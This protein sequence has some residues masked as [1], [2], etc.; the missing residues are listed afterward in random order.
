MGGCGRELDNIFVERFWRSV[1]HEDIY[2]KGNGTPVELKHGLAKYFRFY[3]T[4]R[5]HQ[6]LGYKTP[7]EVYDSATGS[8][9][10]TV[11]KFSQKKSSDRSSE[12]KQ[13]HQSAA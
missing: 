5:P 7:D 2:L 1:T 8:G 13:Q 9:T 6:S 12:V 3:N 10:C 4:E 11:D